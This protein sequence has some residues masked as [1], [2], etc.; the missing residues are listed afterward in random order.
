KSKKSKDPKP[1]KVSKPR[2]PPT[3]PPYE[4]M[5]KEAIVT[6][7]EK[8]GSSQYAIAKC[9]EEKQKQLPPN[10]RKLLL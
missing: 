3:H 2:N 6:L 1:K 5:I 7:K 4:E 8:S 10:F 9:V